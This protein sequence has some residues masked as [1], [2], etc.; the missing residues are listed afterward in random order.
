MDI[1]AQLVQNVVIC[2]G[3]VLALKKKTVR[4]LHLTWPMANLLNFWGVL[5][6]SRENKPFQLFFSGSIG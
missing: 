5:T 4:F 1:R 6:F 2:G 3:T